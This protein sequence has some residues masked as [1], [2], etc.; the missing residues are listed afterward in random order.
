[1]TNRKHRA[2]LLYLSVV[3]PLDTGQRAAGDLQYELPLAARNR[4]T[5]VCPQCGK[6]HE[7]LFTIERVPV[8][9][10]GNYPVFRIN[11]SKVLIDTSLPT[12]VLAVPHDAH[13]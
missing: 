2:F 1:M 10:L 5:E 11:G 6:G 9:S 12:G 3:D 8:G 7:I 13:R 4:L